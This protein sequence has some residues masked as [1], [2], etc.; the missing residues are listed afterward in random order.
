M[1]VA[2]KMEA[3]NPIFLFFYVP[4]NTD[5]RVGLCQRPLQMGLLP[6]VKPVMWLSTKWVDSYLKHDSGNE[7]IKKKVQYGVIL[8]DLDC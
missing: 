2:T 5:K 3:I 6:C 4:Y 8:C 1:P 7:G